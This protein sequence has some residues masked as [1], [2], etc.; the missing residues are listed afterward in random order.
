[1]LRSADAA[2]AEH[3]LPVEK[4][5]IPAGAD[6][7]NKEGEILQE[8][9]ETGDP[10]GRPPRLQWWRRLTSG[11]ASPRPQHSYNPLSHPSI[12]CIEDE[13]EEDLPGLSGCC[14]AKQEAEER[15]LQEVSHKGKTEIL[16]SAELLQIGDV[17]RVAP[18]GVL[19]ADGSL[20]VR[21]F[22]SLGYVDIWS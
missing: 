6:R 8:A 5:Q 12:Y 9:T 18:G 19:P 2:V 14:K 3:L 17:V 7:P 10:V 15:E 11:L 1:M 21:P 13:G 16:I 22:L 4:Q 20:L